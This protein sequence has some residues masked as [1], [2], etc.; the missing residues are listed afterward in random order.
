ML[1]PLY[2]NL[3]GSLWIDFPAFCLVSMEQPSIYIG[4]LLVEQPMTT[5]TN[6]IVASYCFYI[7]LQLIR[8]PN[9]DKYTWLWCGYFLL[10]GLSTLLGGI[11][12]HGFMYAFTD[13]WKLPGW[14]CS[15][16]AI[17]ALSMINLFLIKSLISNG[18]W[19]LFLGFSILE[20]G[21]I[22]YC[23]WHDIQFMYVGIHTAIGMLLYVLGISI[24]SYFKRQKRPLHLHLISAV[25][26]TIAATFVFVGEW[27]IHH[28][29]NHV[30]VSHVF[31]Y[32]GNYYLFQAAIVMIR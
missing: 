28:W 13:L 16:L 9:M 1:T 32:V 7:F 11:F 15:I 27:G 2:P 4:Q 20:M 21:V 8:Y 30:D 22:F 10:M 18:W 6:I 31:L 19:K 14:V 12:T 24:Y 25:L 29:F 17:F 5:L 26:A 3:L 23:L